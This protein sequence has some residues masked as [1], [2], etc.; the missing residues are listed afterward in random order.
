MTY[1][2]EVDYAVDITGVHASRAVSLPLPDHLGPSLCLNP[3]VGTLPSRK[4]TGSRCRRVI[5]S[6]ERTETAI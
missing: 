1:F 6:I 2:P 4:T 5:L 3:F